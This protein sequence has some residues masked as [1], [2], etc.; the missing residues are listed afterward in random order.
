M[1]LSP[2]QPNFL[3]QKLVRLLFMLTAL[4]LSN[5][6]AEAQVSV[7][8]TA[9]DPGPTPYTTLKGAFDAINAGDHNGDVLIEI[10][11]STTETASAVLSGSGTGAADYT[12]VLVRPTVLVAISGD[13]TGAVIKLHGADNVT[14]DGRIG[15]EG[16]FL[17]V[18]N[19]STATATAAIWLASV[20]VGNGASNNTLRNLLIQ[21][22]ADQRSSTAATFGILMGGPL[23]QTNSNGDD[24][25]NNSFLSN[26]IT[27]VRYG[28]VTRGVPAAGGNNLGLVIADNVIGPSDFGFSQIG[29]AGLLLQA[30]SGALVT[31]NQIRSV[32][33]QSSDSAFGGDRFGIAI[34]QE[35]WSVDD[36]S[37]LYSGDYTVTRNAIYDIFEQKS[38]SAA[39]IRIG[40]S[41]SGNPT[42]NLV[43]N[44]FIYGIMA[45]GTG[46]DQVVGLAYAAG[47]SD[48]IVF[49]TILLFDVMDQ[50]SAP[51][52][53][54]GNGIRISGENGPN[55]ANLTMMNNSVSM[56][57]QSQTAGLRF[58]AI[59]ANSASYDFGSGGLDYNNYYLAPGNPQLATGG[60]A[61]TTGGNAATTE[62][63]SLSN[64]Q[65]A[66]AV[67]QDSHSLAA[68]P[69]PT[70]PALILFLVPGS[71]NL[72]AGISIAGVSDD[73]EGQPRPATP[74]VGADELNQAGR[75]RF[76]AA[77]FNGLEG[78]SVTVA[79]ER[80]DGNETAAQV[81][82]ATVGG[83]ATSGAA[84]G[85][86][87]DYIATNGTLSWADLE[88]GIKDFSVTLCADAVFDPTDFVDI[89]LANAV[90]ATL[91]TPNTAVL[92]I[93]EL[94]SGTFDVGVG[95][96]I[97]SLTNLG[98]M[99]SALNQGTVTGNVTIRITS[100]LLAETGVVALDELDGGFSLTIRPSGAARTISGSGNKGIIRLNGADQVTLDGSL[101][102]GTA[103]GLGGD[104]SLRNLTVRNLSPSVASAVIALHSGPNGSQNNTLRN[105][106]VFG[107]DPAQTR[108]AI[109]LGGESIG[110]DGAD[111]D[112]NR[113][114]NC[115]LE[116][117][118]GGIYAGG[119]SEG[120]PSL[121]TIITMNEMTATGGDR[122]QRIG[123]YVRHDD[124]GEVTD[125]DVGGIDFS[126]N[127]DAVGIGLGTAA[128][129]D[130]VPGVLGRVVNMLV[131]R[132]RVHGVVAS[133]PLGYSAAG[134]AV[135][136]GSLG[137]N[138]VVNN[139]ISGVISQA[140]AQDLVAGIFVVSTGADTRLYY[141]SVSLTGDRGSLASQV[142]S[143][144]LAI[145][146]TT[147]SVEWRDNIFANTQTA[148]GGANAK[149]F[150]IG[151]QATSFAG[152]DADH[153]DYFVSGANAAFFRTGGLGAV[154]TDHPNLAAWQATT[155]DD[156][157][158]LAV[159][160]LFVSV[161]DLHLQAT[162]PVQDLAAPLGS[163]TTDFDGQPR[164]DSAPDI[165]ADE[166]VV[167]ELADLGIT[168][169]DE[170]THIDPGAT[171]VYTIV[172]SNA[173][174][175]A[176][177]AATV[178]DIF[179][180]ACVSHSFTSVATGGATG[181]TA[182]PSA[183]DLTDTLSLP[184]GASVTYTA[185]CTI[186]VTATGG[187]SNTATIT[188]SGGVDDPT[189]GNNSAN[190]TDVINGVVLFND[191][192]E[193]GDLSPWNGS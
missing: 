49:N 176:D 91:D 85:P 114:E 103:S 101:T 112:H 153:N 99:F 90:T 72:A 136:G 16:R 44:N 189:P 3:S 137:P 158:S 151:L 87:V 71:P 135:A 67:P 138:T 64:W 98:G 45:N 155:G 46:G 142:P 117:A 123:V 110:I 53:T 175:G 48:R 94:L 73:F 6:A 104:P 149:T 82:Y 120:N 47:H 179:P 1:K 50:G 174:P 148:S 38:F 84:C 62:L 181:N 141:N 133:H 74:D 161:S 40:T 41:R 140:T 60:L 28:I 134:I 75:L 51:S 130:Q 129:G 100:D 163:V 52:S 107:A 43:A 18:V 132:N 105:L 177:P 65:A 122:L 80:V 29:K 113:V 23:L 96:N 119:I 111:N 69:N 56:T 63:A 156:A 170:L 66:F 182:G 108:Y 4:A 127:D 8:A 145:V 35:S 97:Q 25:D 166:V 162:S 55:N 9:G 144:G 169:T 15:G 167:L 5:A 109:H 146:G 152:F 26:S 186:A 86:G 115:R 27:R 178:T 32:G 172:A 70:A 106:N 93:G 58:Y 19:T 68:N 116:K 124:G 34:G 118:V 10:T 157:S 143:F 12:S 154:G 183:S 139:V 30:D 147:G 160:P 159:D 36:T 24:N 95:Q 187:L 150:S 185:S 59:T 180:A 171:V 14:I 33:T 173:G 11:A 191:G 88:S 126:N 128:A 37:S 89:A 39:A 164:S 57:P 61:T 193:S 76:V 102:G 81:D 13:I 131:A 17:S 165:G 42:N 184:A 20:G 83:T 21:C 7:T 54:Y 190:D 31:R 192:F 121:G 79:V 168:K 78:S 22:G 2:N 92:G 77:N 125:N 188:A